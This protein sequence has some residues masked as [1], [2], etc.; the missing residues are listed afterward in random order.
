MQLRTQ[1]W[2]GNCI[3]Y[4]M[5]KSLKINWTQVSEDV[6][7]LDYYS[8]LAF[9]RNKTSRG[10]FPGQLPSLCP[11]NKG[12]SKNFGTNSSAPSWCSLHWAKFRTPTPLRHISFS[13]I[14]PMH[15]GGLITRGGSEMILWTYSKINSVTL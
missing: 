1:L 3:P 9:P 7:F 8:G 13:L 14:L 4:R 15:S 6:T 11:W 10:T 5:I 2:S 12:R